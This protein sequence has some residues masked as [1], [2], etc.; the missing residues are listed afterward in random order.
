MNDPEDT[1]ETRRAQRKGQ[2]ALRRANATRKP[3]K[4]AISDLA[5]ASGEMRRALHGNS[6][7]TPP[8]RR[9]QRRG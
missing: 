5:A 8:A 1:P 2:D 9:I 4:A 7:Y 3:S 6:R